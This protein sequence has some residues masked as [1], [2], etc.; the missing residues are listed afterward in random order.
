MNGGAMTAP[1]RR[2]LDPVREHLEALQ[3][4]TELTRWFRREREPAMVGVTP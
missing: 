1:A 2:T 4:S 3:I